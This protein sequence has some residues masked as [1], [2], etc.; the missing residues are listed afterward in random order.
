M[1]ATKTGETLLGVTEV[2]TAGDVLTVTVQDVSVR[3]FI[4]TVTV[5]E[6]VPEAKAEVQHMIDV[7]ERA[8]M[9]QV[10]PPVKV[11]LT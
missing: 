11:M 10:D 2:I 5:A 9:L 1:F 3:P 8:K 6:V 4:E 7:V